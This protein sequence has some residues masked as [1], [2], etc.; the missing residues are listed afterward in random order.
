[1]PRKTSKKPVSRDETKQRTRDALIQ[2]GL[3]LFTE[4]GLDVP[5]LDAICDRAGFTRGAFYVHF[6]DRLQIRHGLIEY[7]A[8]A[9]FEPQPL[10]HSQRDGDLTL[11]GKRNSHDRHSK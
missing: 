7:Q 9:G 5:S 4:Q 3:E 11:F 10:A 8:H 2:A 1:M 6:A